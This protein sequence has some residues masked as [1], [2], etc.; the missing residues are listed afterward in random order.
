MIG[1]KFHTTSGENSGNAGI[2]VGLS[3]K[4]VGVGAGC[5]IVKIDAKPPFPI[6][7]IMK[8]VLNTQGDRTEFVKAIVRRQV[9]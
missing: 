6:C 8:S 3:G 1:S 9:L 5:L 4:L 2:Q 7:L